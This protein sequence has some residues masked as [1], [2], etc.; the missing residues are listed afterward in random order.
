MFSFV[1][2]YLGFLKFIPG[3]ALLFDALLKLWTL[4]VNPKLLDWI[5][6]IEE[7]VLTWPGT[8]ATTHKYGGLQF[9]YHGKELG[10][11]HSNGLMD[12]LLSRKVKEQVKREHVK[13]QDH[14]AFNNSGWISL[15]IINSDD[16][17]LALILFKQAYQ[18]HSH[19]Q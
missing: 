8:T 4:N 7:E 1:T 14:H 10:H 19:K 18:W 17:K 3:M 11:I 9:N 6:G 13:V 5:D 2:R 16:S 15:Y 12:M